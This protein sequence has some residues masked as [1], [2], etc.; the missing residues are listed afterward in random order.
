MA[1]YL[2]E[3]KGNLK[4]FIIWTA[5]I[6]VLMSLFMAMYPS[7]ASQGN[8]VNEML[9]GFSPELM[10]IFSFD[11]I[12]FT[13]TMDYY[14]YIFQ[15]IF[16]TALIQFMILGANLLSKE[17][18]SGTINFLYA[19][20]LS[21]RKIVGVKSLAGITAIA[22]FFIVYTAAVLVVLASINRTGLDYGA[23]FLISVSMALG[24]IM[25]LSIG[26]LLSMFITKARAVM[27]ASIGIVLVLYV[28]SMFVNMKSEL[29]WLKYITPFQYFDSRT[30]LRSGGIDWVYIVLSAGIA[31]AALCISLLI[32]NRRDLKS[33]P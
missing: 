11:M 6:I 26:M 24:Q 17:E 27:S 2:R 3:L 13:Q 20:P 14:V 8:A 5:C 25:M 16:L 30:I 28:V 15:Y 1:L 32:Y 23:I 10:Q 7:F 22:A 19:K 12:D 31:A 21:R 29:N 18:D 33:L 9:S 4:S